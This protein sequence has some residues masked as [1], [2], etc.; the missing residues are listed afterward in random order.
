M[1]GQQGGELWQAPFEGWLDRFVRR[2][3]LDATQLAWPE[4]R[5]EIVRFLES[6]RPVDRRP[7]REAM[8]EISPALRT[9]LLCAF[10]EERSAQRAVMAIQAA[11]AA[12][13]LM[14]AD[15][16]EVVVRAR[17]L[18]YCWAAGSVAGGVD[19]MDSPYTE[20]RDPDAQVWMDAVME[21]GSLQAVDSVFSSVTWLD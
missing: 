2:S 9:A 17:L 14:R 16:F 6:G 10:E 19:P 1:A 20:L 7:A 4:V 15:I 5:P 21:A 3:V 11:R 8:Q 18:R 12:V 13:G